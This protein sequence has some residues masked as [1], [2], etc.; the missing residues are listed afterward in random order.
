MPGLRACGVIVA[1][2]LAGVGPGWAQDA[3]PAAG[4]LPEQRRWL[5]E[6]IQLG[7][8]SG[9]QALVEDALAR[10]RMLAPNDPPTLLAL[11][12]VQLSTSKFDEAE[13]TRKRLRA[14]AP[15][16][17]EQVAADRL[18]TA[19]RGSQHQALQQARLLAKGGRSAEALAIY[20]RLFDDNPPGLQLGLEYWTLRGSE[21]AGREAALRGASALARDYPGN[22][23]VQRLQMALLEASGRGREASALAARMRPDPAVRAADAQAAIDALAE[24][25]VA[26]ARAPHAAPRAQAAAAAPAA[27]AAPRV[28]DPAVQEAQRAQRLLDAGRNAQAEQAY[29]HALQRRP[30][31][32]DWRGGLGMALLRQG[33]RAAALEQFELALRYRPAG[34]RGG[35]W[36]ELVASTR[37]WLLLEQADA[38]LQA[39]QA[40][41]AHA[42]YEQARRQSASGVE[43]VLGLADVALARGNNA[44]AEQQLLAARRLDPGDG[45]AL[46]KLV[47]FYARTDVERLDALVAVLTPAQRDRHADTLRQ[48]RIARLE[49]QVEAARTQVEAGSGSL[50]MLIDLQQD[51]RQHAPDDPWLA[52][53]LARDVREAKRTAEADAVVADMVAR[54]GTQP[55]ARYAQALYLSSADRGDDALAALAALPSSQW[56]DDMHAL[57]RRLER[58]QLWMRL[59][60]LRA[61]GREAEALALLQQQPDSVEKYLLL[62]D[63]A[64][65]RDSHA[66]AAGWYARVLAEQPANLEARLGEVESLVSAGNTDA[67]RKALMAMPAIPADATGTRRRLADAWLALGEQDRARALLQEAVAALDAP[68]AQLRRDLARLTRDVDARAALDM[69]ALAMRDANL[70]PAAAASPRDDRA[71]TRATRATDGDDWLARSLRGDVDAFYQAQ[72]PTLTLMQDTARRSDGAPGFSQLTRDTRIAHV[73]APFAGGHGW[74]RLEQITMDAGRFPEIAGGGHYEDFGSCAIALRD[75]QGAAHVPP[76]CTRDTHQRQVSAAG[77][78]AGWKRSDDRFEFDLG[79]TPAGF[80]FANWV[81]GATVSGDLGVL[82]WSATASRRPMT[83][84]LLSQ[85]GAVDPRSGIRWGGVLA[86]GITLGLGYDK[87]GRNGVWSSWGWHDIGG[88]NVASNNRLRAM[89]GWYHKLVQCTDMRLDVGLSTMWWRYRRDL[90]GYSLGQGGYYSPQQYLSLGLPVSFA[91][92]NDNWSVRLDGSYSWSRS[93]TD[94]AAQYPLPGLAQQVVDEL[95]AQ[96]GM[97]LVMDPAT[98][99]GGSSSG[100]GYRLYGAVE[101]R[102]GDHLVLGANGNLQRSRDFSPNTF[103][104]YLRYVFRPWQGNLPLPVAPL[105][106]YGEFR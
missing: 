16:R 79:R 87:G 12:E 71:L 95:S 29:R 77:F 34:E 4:S 46:R 17:R 76:P 74:A 45:N 54:V 8:E 5:L 101:R 65:E 50:A 35:K 57:A 6:Q 31:Q 26:V 13:A 1:V 42:L 85:A 88:H 11:L 24:A 9:R 49:A 39:G 47:Q 53:R 93:R 44:E 98:S 7:H 14:V 73:E 60:Q 70:L 103:Q 23:A 106:P 78:A 28:V 64:R 61:D 86:Q 41:Q 32:S 92:R 48:A 18:W 91:W 58:E 20:R 51:L 10:L 3:L 102:L 19:W 81:G 68:D 90:G 2:G 43:A 38:A 99:S 52:Y 40:A 22:S 84:S 83:N 62:G 75:A 25:R 27:V 100:T 21:P 33:K 104:L 37:Y 96:A 59:R 72:N 105:S 82:G 66:E 97:P 67:A 80:V 89:G 56:T 30:R 63:W 36:R 15:G 69:Y 94:S 55:A